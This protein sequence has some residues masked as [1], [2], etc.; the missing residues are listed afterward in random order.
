MRLKG[1]DVSIKKL[2]YLFIYYSFLYYLPSSV[3]IISPVGYLSKKLRY[4]C[5]RRIFKYCGKNVN[6]ERKANFG[7][8][9]NIEIGDNSGIGIN[10]SIPSDTIIGKNVMMGPNCYIL[11]INHLFDKIETPMI[12]QGFSTP[13]TTYIGD[14]VWIGRDVLMTPGRVIKQ[15]SII[16]GGCVLCKDFPEY[17]IVGGNPSVLIKTRR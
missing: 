9:L 3:C 7:S 8:G 10:A 2:F 17:S 14:D 13:K 5:C 1:R 15:G 11:A 16:A 6:I 4:L 12:K